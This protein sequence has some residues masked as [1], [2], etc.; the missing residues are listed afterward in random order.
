MTVKHRNGIGI[1]AALLV[2]SF[3]TDLRAQ[4]GLPQIVFDPTE[5]ANVLQNVSVGLKTYTTIL[6]VYQLAQ[7]MAVTL[8][9]LPAQY[10]YAL[11]SQWALLTPANLCRGCQVWANASNTATPV[12]DPTY[13]GAVT[14]LQDY[15]MLLLMLPADAQAR[16][17]A[18]LANS[19][20]LPQAA[21]NNDLLALGAARTNDSVMQSYIQQ[22]QSDVLNV[23]FVSQIQTAQAGNACQTVQQQQSSLTNNMLGLLVNHASIEAAQRVDAQTKAINSRIAR[24]ILYN[25]V[26]EQTS[27]IDAALNNWGRN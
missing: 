25:S 12:S 14:Q 15:S 6:Q 17:H 4:F 1:L 27:S 16:L 11:L 22:C 5:N 2:L 8:Q 9:N 7:Q 3:A 20:Y 26:Q 24:A 10:R 18:Q 13:G 21:V 19:V 23:S